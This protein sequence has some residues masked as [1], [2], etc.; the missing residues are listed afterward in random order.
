M[1]KHMVE[2]FAAEK[3]ESLLFVAVGI[4]VIGVAIWLWMNGY[5]L[6]FMAFPLAA[7]ALIHIRLAPGRGPARVSPQRSNQTASLGGYTLIVSVRARLAELR[8]I[9]A[10]RRPGSAFSGIQGVLYAGR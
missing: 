5:R 3:Q 4:L 8:K 10:F 7:I 1:I 9:E 2:Y 6:R